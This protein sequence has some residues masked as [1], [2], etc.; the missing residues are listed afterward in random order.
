MPS[1]NEK[2]D[3]LPPPEDG[4]R[5]TPYSSLPVPGETPPD[6]P[7]GSLHSLSQRYEIL[8]ELGR[9]GMGIVYKARDRETGA[10][11]A[12][13][14]LRPE[15]AAVTAEIERFKS[16]LLLARKVT[17]KNVCRIY[18]LLRVGDA[19]VISM[20]YVDGESLRQFLTRYRAASIRKS[21]EWAQQICSALSEAHRQGVVHRDLKPENIVIDHNGNVKVMDFG[22]ARSLETTTATTGMMIGTPAYMSPEQAEGKPADARSDI[23]SLGLILYEMFTGRPGL[24]AESPIAL[25]LKQI[26]E[27]PPA[28]REVEPEIPA[29]V[30]KAILKCLEKNPAK[31]FQTVD[32]LEAAL[33]MVSEAKGEDEGAEVALPYHLLNFQRMDVALFIVGLASFGYFWFVF[34][35]FIYWVGFDTPAALRHGQPIGALLFLFGVILFAARGL[36][37]YRGNRASAVVAFIAAAATARLFQTSPFLRSKVPGDGE[38]SYW[39]WLAGLVCLA[40]VACYGFICSLIYYINKVSPERIASLLSFNRGFSHWQPSGV[41]ILRGVAIGSALAGTFALSVSVATHSGSSRFFFLVPTW[42]GDL[43]G[44]GASYHLGVSWTFLESLL[45]ACVLLGFPLA[46]LQRAV[47]RKVSL[48]LLITALWPAS[49]YALWGMMLDPAPMFCIAAAVQATLLTMLYLRYDL[50]T[51]FCAVFAA[52]SWLILYKPEHHGPHF[53]PSALAHRM[54]LESARE[55]LGLLPLLLLL[56]LGLAVVYQR[57]IVAAYLRVKTVLE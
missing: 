51:L 15:I 34:P 40:M 44:A 32:E 12:L 31:R 52:E 23:Y 19:A 2:D 10:I 13:K 46:L 41:A 43:A 35:G 24:Q 55:Y 1:D 22:I 16:E 11:V 7:A 38:A 42:P 21:V 17:H 50:V 47:Q 27:T 3:F 9:G 56:A 45:G 30:E 6:L 36:H 28:P 37:R 4:Q 25:A 33:S 57:R 54:G 14:F 26:H 8:A 49:H 48:I 29:Y 20:E 5:T 18:E 39:L 53:F